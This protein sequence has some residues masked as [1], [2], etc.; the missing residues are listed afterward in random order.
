MFALSWAASG[1][2]RFAASVGVDARRS[3]TSSKSG[4]SFSCPI[5]ETIGVVAAAAALTNA[6]SLKT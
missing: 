6:S 4:R 5:A 2:V 3:A 1:T